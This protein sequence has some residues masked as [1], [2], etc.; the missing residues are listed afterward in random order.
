[1]TEQRLALPQRS[2]KPLIVPCTWR[3]PAATAASVLATA[4]SPSLWQWMPTGA[5]RTRRR[6]RATA[7]ATSRRQRAAVGVAEDEPVGAR[8]LP[9]PAGRRARIGVGAVAV[10]EMLG[11][12]DRPRARCAFRKRDG[13]ARSSRGSRPASCARTSSTWR[14]QRLAEDARP[15]GV[16]ASS[17]AWRFASSSARAPLRR[18]LP[19]A[20]RRARRSGAVVQ[21]ARRT[22]RPWGWT[23]ASRP[24]CSRCR[25]RPAAARCRACPPARTRRRRPGCRRGASCHTG[26]Q[27]DP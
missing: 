8:L 16:P 25:T 19:K 9:P 15:A 5:R 1:M 7:S 27:S 2:P 24:R 26:E 20:V 4:S 11:V 23:P 6:R 21:R 3:A 17:S 14:S 18:V 12:E 10:E 22:P 13:V